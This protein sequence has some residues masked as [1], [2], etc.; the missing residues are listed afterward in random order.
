M[1][2]RIVAFVALL[3]LAM[4]LVASVPSPALALPNN[5][6]GYYG[7]QQTTA[8]DQAVSYFTIPTSFDQSGGNSG[9]LRNVGLNSNYSMLF[10]AGVQVQNSAG[11][12]QYLHPIIQTYQGGGGPNP[13]PYYREDTDKFAYVND[14]LF[15]QVMVLDNTHF[16]A[17]VTDTTQGWKV[18]IGSQYCAYAYHL[19]GINAEFFDERFENLSLGTCWTLTSIMSDDFLSPEAHYQGEGGNVYHFLTAMQPQT[20]TTYDDAFDGPGGTDVV[21]YPGALGHNANFSENFVWT[22]DRDPC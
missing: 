4:G 13:C 6:S 20:E 12:I 17:I 15:A 22:G 8:L 9:W 21:E 14:N 18:H 19:Y 10:Q 2:K 16:D 1:R 11:G 3:G 5:H 7:Y